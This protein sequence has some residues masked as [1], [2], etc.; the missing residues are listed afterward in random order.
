[1]YRPLEEGESISVTVNGTTHQLVYTA[2]S[3]IGDYLVQL[4]LGIV[5][6]MECSVDGNT[7]IIYNTDP[8]L[9]QISCASDIGG[10][11]GWG[12]GYRYGFNGMEK[13]NEN[14]EGAYD[15]GARILDARLGRWMSVDPLVDK[16]PKISPYSFVA[17]E[18]IIKVDP[19]GE[20]IKPGNQ[21]TADMFVGM[22]CQ[23]LGGVSPKQAERIFNLKTTTTSFQYDDKNVTTNP[24]PQTRQPVLTI[25]NS[26]RIVKR[27]NRVIDKRVRKGKMTENQATEARAL[28]NLLSETQTTEL[29][30]VTQGQLTSST[31]AVGQTEA[32]NRTADPSAMTIISIT[33]NPQ[34]E[35]LKQQ[36]R[37]VNPAAI[38]S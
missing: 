17:N 15:F 5:D 38:A 25:D 20:D 34:Y 24:N 35:A 27:F 6:Y 11:S 30:I 37:A 26:A 31:A 21:E 12:E 28:F 23:V 7:L 16:Y 14:F 4:K 1:M 18:P 22:L 33:D 19:D 9:L 29:I 8:S 3:S 13:D 2:G 32:N 36:I 10:F